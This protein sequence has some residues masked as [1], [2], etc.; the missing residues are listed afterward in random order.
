MPNTEETRQSKDE[1]LIQRLRNWH[2][3][4][5]FTNEVAERME[6]LIRERDEWRGRAADRCEEAE[7]W[8]RKYGNEQESAENARS[9]INEMRAALDLA[10]QYWSVRQQRYKNRSPIW[11]QQ[12]KQALGIVAKKTKQ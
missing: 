2:G 9:K 7:K 4:T 11:V 5:G 12:A 8:F 1:E 3:V 6:E 10:L